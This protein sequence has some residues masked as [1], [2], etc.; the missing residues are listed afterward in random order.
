VGWQFYIHHG[1]NHR[2]K[3]GWYQGPFDHDSLEKP[4]EC[5][6]AHVVKQ[7]WGRFRCVGF[8]GSVTEPADDTPV[9]FAEHLSKLTATQQFL[10]RDLSFS[11]DDIHA[12]ADSIEESSALI[13]SDG[14]FF[15]HTQTA[16]FQLRMETGAKTNQ[17]SATQ[18]VPGQL[19]DNDAYRAEATGLLAGL[20]LIEAICRFRNI[21]EGTIVMGCD[22]TT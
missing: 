14:S 20:S 15:K 11:E 4:F 12:I 3:G 19:T 2:P 18:Y 22:G 16:A 13:V 5:V 7:R 6:R 8:T 10:L 1:H 17:V 9:T 21:I